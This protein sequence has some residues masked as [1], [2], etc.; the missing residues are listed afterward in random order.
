M[1]HIP[2]NT[3][4]YIDA[5]GTEETRTIIREELIAI[6]TALCTFSTHSWIGIF[7]DSLSSLHAIW[8]H[9]TNP[10]TTSAK[11]YHHHKLLLHNIRDLLEARQRAGLSTNL[12]K[13]MAHTNIRGNDLEHAAAELAVTHYDTL[14]T[15]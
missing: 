13:I 15:S 4:I 10:G 9:H 3:T 7:T 8:H 6:Y 14:P 12:H 5:A 11:H 2:T 1:V